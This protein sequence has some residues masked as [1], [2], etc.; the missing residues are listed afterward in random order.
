MEDFLINLINALPVALVALPLGWVGGMLNSYFS[1]KGENL[2]TKEDIEEITNK[3]EAVKHHFDLLSRKS[4]ALTERQIQAF[5]ELSNELS[6]LQI[7]CLR[8]QQDANEHAVPFEELP[9]KS[10]FQRAVHLQ[11]ISHRQR[12]FISKEIFE[13]I[14]TL[15]QSVFMVGKHELYEDSLSKIKNSSY[16]DMRLKAKELMSEMRNELFHE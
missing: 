8:K 7:Y 10:T 5:D 15:S 4:S 6:E 2:A 16:N 1:K 11:E 14:G 12:I 13:K 3:V 9:Q